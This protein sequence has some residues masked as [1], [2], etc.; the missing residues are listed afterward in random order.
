[1]QPVEY[2][3]RELH[4]RVLQG[5]SVVAGDG[6]VDGEMEGGDVKVK[7]KGKGLVGSTG[8]EMLRKWVG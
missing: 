1:M 2:Y 4:V 7:G 8:T 6:N 5:G 3:V